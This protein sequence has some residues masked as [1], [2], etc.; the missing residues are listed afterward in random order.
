MN[1]SAQP[2]AQPAAPADAGQP[3]IGAVSDEP[4]RNYREVVELK[5]D[6]R[7]VQRLIKDQLL[8][9]LASQRQPAP[10]AQPEEPARRAHPRPEAAA[11]GGA[12]MEAVAALERKIELKD[13]FLDLGIKSAEHREMLEAIVAKA[14]PANVREFLG[15]YAASLAPAPSSAQPSA[16][17][18]QMPQATGRSNSGTPAAPVSGAIAT[19][20]IYAIDPAVWLTMSPADRRAAWEKQRSN[21]GQGDRVLDVTRRALLNN[22]SR[23]R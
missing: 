13:A 17:A 2:D 11:G 10:V 16:R 9:A 18:M 6:V 23:Q 15:K 5:R 14:S 7:E 20:D 21:S 3:T 8:P 19:D 1:P 4:L 12:A 22:R